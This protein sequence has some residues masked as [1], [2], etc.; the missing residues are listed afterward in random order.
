[1]LRNSSALRYS[2][3]YFST[4][5]LSAMPMRKKS[6]SRAP[7]LPLSLSSSPLILTSSIL[8]TSAPSE[9][10][11]FGFMV[12]SRSYRKHSLAGDLTPPTSASTL[13]SFQSTSST[14]SYPRSTPSSTETEIT[15]TTSPSILTKPLPGGQITYKQAIAFVDMLNKADEDVAQEVARIKDCIQEVRNLAAEYKVERLRRREN[16]GVTNA[17]DKSSIDAGDS[18]LDF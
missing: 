12:K 6:T 18:W 8:P 9:E 10:E 15:D 5:Y 11:V 1:M 13:S 17:E 4:L 2:E 14:F 16:S 3:P 7:H